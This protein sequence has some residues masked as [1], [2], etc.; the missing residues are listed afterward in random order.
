MRFMPT[1]I[2]MLDVREHRP[3]S[4]QFNI[5]DEALFLTFRNNE[6]PPVFFVLHGTDDAERLRF[7]HRK[8][9]IHHH[10]HSP[11]D[12]ALDALVHKTML[13]LTR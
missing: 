10:L 7:A 5:A 2:D 3:A 9:T 1:D 4:K 11:F 8:I 13:T 12:M 6:H